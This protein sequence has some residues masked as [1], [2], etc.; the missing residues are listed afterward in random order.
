MLDRPLAIVA[1]FLLARTLFPAAAAEESRPIQSGTVGQIAV[2][3]TAT[4]AGPKRIACSAAVA[5]WYSVDLGEAAAGET[6]AATLWFDPKTGE[7]SILNAS[8]NRM[9]VQS[10]WCGIAGRSWETRSAVALARKAGPPPGPMR[11]VCSPEGEQ[12][13]CR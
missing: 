3:F 4:N 5:H 10:L 1:T 6:V 2:P 7:I 8:E 11:L 12:L 13:A 9:P